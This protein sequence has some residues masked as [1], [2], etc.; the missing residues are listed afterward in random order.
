VSQ[1]VPA[2]DAE[3]ATWI[4]AALQTFGQ[5]VT[6]LV[7]IG[8][9][10]YVRVFHPA[11]R[12]TDEGESAPLPWSAIAA[13]NGTQAHPAMQLPPLTGSENFLYQGQPGVY[14]GPP[15]RGSLPAELVSPLVGVLAR[16]T[17]TPDRCWFALWNGFG[18]TGAD[19]RSAATFHLPSREYH[20]L[21]GPIAAAAESML[22]APCAQSANLWWP[23]DRSWCVATEID[24]N[25]TYVGCSIVCRDQILAVPELETAPVDPNDGISLNSDPVNASVR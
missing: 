21:A 24:L 4:V 3:P 18:A 12:R 25:T 9:A 16:N 7:P 10:A 13:A 6:S 8:F 22:P 2:A 11:Y 5:S 23:D 19:V 20:L 15:C 14:D 1:L 17:T